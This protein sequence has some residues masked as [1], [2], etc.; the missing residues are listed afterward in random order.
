M[1]STITAPDTDP[2]VALTQFL[3]ITFA[4]LKKYKFYYWFA[5]PAF[6][7]KPSWEI[8]ENGWVPAAGILT[9]A[10]VSLTCTGSEVVNV[11]YRVHS[12]S[13]PSNPWHLKVMIM[14]SHHSS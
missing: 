11:V 10:A 1:W 6:V 3:L 9:P 7:A 5:F 4:D 13:Q 8:A 12:W 14:P 2:S